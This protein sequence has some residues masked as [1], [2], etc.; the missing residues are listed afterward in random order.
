MDSKTNHTHVRNLVMSAMLLAVG[1]V[2]PF[3]NGQIPQIG[4][5][6]LPMHLPV[7]VCGLI[8]GWPYG[9]V[10]GFLLPLLRY[11]ADAKRACHGV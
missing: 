11:A 10:I 1:I 8:C 2:L 5:M 9:G 3:F 4:G 6:L 7:L